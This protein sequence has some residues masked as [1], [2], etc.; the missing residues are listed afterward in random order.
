MN[1]SSS[2]YQCMCLSFVTFIYI[3]MKDLVEKLIL[4]GANINSVNLDGYSALLLAANNGKLSG[5][6][7]RSLFCSVADEIYQS[8]VAG[9][10]QTKKKFQTFVRTKY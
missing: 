10:K 6:F 7:K 4:N 3:G 2:N 5:I 8:Y 1:H 9:N